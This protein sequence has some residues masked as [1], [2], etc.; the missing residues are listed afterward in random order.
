MILSILTI[1][2]AMIILFNCRKI[3]KL[4]KSIDDE[5]LTSSTKL[6]SYA[7]SVRVF[8][9]ML[10]LLGMIFALKRVFE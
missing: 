5:Y 8:G 1:I 2:V 10:L 6:R 4:K 9:V 7:F 3:A